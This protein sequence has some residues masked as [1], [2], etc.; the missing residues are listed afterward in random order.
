MQRLI[1]SLF[2]LLLATTALAQPRYG[3][4]LRFG[5][6][7][8]IISFDPHKLPIP[9]PTELI[10]DTLLRVDPQGNIIP[11]LAE[12]WSVSPDGLTW[13]FHLREDVTFHNGEPLL[14]SDVVYSID[15]IKDP[16]TASPRAD[17]F[18]PV[19]SVT[20]ADDHTVVF[21]LGQPFSPLASKVAFSAHAIVSE[22]VAR[23]NDL[24]Q[25]VIGTGPFKFIDYTPQVGVTLE[26][27]ESYWETD[28]DGN[29]LPYLDGVDITIF[30]DATTRT[31]ALQAGTIDFITLTPEGDVALLRGCYALRLNIEL[32]EC[33]VDS[34]QRGAT[35]RKAQRAPI[36][37]DFS[38]T[39]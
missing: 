32:L 14:A 26:R 38:A 13:T 35:S 12:R 16:A 39:L 34:I 19:E 2:F 3:G 1:L 29:P 21:A 15:R 25:V 30:G 27:Y 5:I 31:I 6:N 8:D 20:A 24:T 10:Y 11:D 37:S 7:Y 4:T 23:N 33:V 36:Y 22:D 28:A 17:D 18:T 9:H